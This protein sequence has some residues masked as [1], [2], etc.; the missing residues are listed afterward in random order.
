MKSKIMTLDDFNEKYSVVRNLNYI[1]G[2]FTLTLRVKE[3]CNDTVCDT[4]SKDFAWPELHA[5][6][7]DTKIST[8]DSE[9][10]FENSML[11][12]LILD[13][14]NSYGVIN[15]DFLEISNGPFN[16]VIFKMP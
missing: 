8:R 1:V 6:T 14:L 13:L 2:G 10:V 4:F 7:Q 16:E 15:C 11:L 9:I 12:E 3:R 5:S